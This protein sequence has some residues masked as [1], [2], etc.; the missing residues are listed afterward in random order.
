MTYR[1]KYADRAK[2]LIKAVA[3]RRKKIRQMGVEYKGGKCIIRGYDK[4]IQALD[5]HHLGHTGKDFGIS[6]KGYTHSCSWK[7]VRD[8]LDK[9][10]L[11]CANCHD[12]LHAKKTPLKIEE[13]RGIFKKIEKTC[14]KCSWP[15]LM[16]LRK[17]KKPWIFCFNPV[18]ESNRERLE[19]YRKKKEQ[20]NNS[21]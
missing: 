13:L 20:E 15:M 2:Y 12:M 9:C 17:G 21:G 1:R 14:E 5:F 6:D 18:C 4:C 11:V 3:K 16:S 7:K 19:E 8:E 10:I